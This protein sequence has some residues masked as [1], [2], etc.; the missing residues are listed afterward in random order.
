M[1]CVL[2]VLSRISLFLSPLLTCTSAQIPAEGGEK[3]FNY[4]Q[5]VASLN[6]LQNAH[7]LGG[8]AGNS[9]GWKT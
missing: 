9:W 3:G 2:L 7:P 8:F 1:P 4:L 6:E 5:F